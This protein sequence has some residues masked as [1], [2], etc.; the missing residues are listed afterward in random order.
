MAE[1]NTFE[2]R[3]YP[4]IF[5]GHGETPEAARKDFDRDYACKL[6]VLHGFVYWRQKP[7]TELNRD[8][9]AG[10]LQYKAIARVFVSRIKYPDAEP[11]AWSGGINPYRSGMACNVKFLP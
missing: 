8:F 4:T 10:T 7:A 11:F 1:S 5:V 2:A 9:E 3:L 6:P